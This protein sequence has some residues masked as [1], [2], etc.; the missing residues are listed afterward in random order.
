MLT[1]RINETTLLQM[2]IIDQL[3]WW[4]LRVYQ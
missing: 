4:P 3:Y 2:T 1:E